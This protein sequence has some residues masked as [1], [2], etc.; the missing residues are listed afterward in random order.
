MVPRS[1]TPALRGLSTLAGA[2]LLALGA[3]SVVEGDPALHVVTLGILVLGSGLATIE[4]TLRI[5]VVMVAVGF[6][7]HL[8]RGG[9]VSLLD[10]ES[11]V[12]TPS[13][14]RYDSVGEARVGGATALLAANVPAAVLVWWLVHRRRRRPRRPSQG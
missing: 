14:G 6:W 7:S 12:G 4:R 2:G 11:V 8:T 3:W 9:L 5:G 1:S 10:P 13:G